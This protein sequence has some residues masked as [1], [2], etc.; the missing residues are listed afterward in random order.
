MW[1]INATQEVNDASQWPMIVAVTIFLS[2]LM[3]GIVSLRIY[4][5]AHVAKAIGGDDYIILVTA[6]FALVYNALC[7]AQ[8][9]YGLGLPIASRPKM[10]IDPYSKLNFAGRPFYQL[11]ISGFKA[12]FCYALLRVTRT[13]QTKFLKIYRATVTAAIVLIVVGHIAGTFILIFQCKP[14]QKSWYPRT[15]GTCL[16]NDTTFYWL[17]GFSILSDLISIFLPLPL[18]LSLNLN[19][20]KRWGLIVPFMLGFFTTICS[21]LRLYQI[22][23]IARDGNSTMLVLWGTIEFNV[24]TMTACL[25]TLVPLFKYFRNRERRTNARSKSSGNW[26]NPATRFFRE[27]VEKYREVDPKTSS[28]IR[29]GQGHSSASGRMSWSKAIEDTQITRTTEVNI[30]HEIRSINDTDS[31]GQHSVMRAWDVRD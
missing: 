29:L 6:I 7:I 11:G 18:L 24:G 2:T 3:V 4:A 25:P 31:G 16:P 28:A 21:V 22:T 30:S 5:R 26:S 27:K 10:N 1:V 15:K 17:G 14:V 23:I 20:R 13:A 19:K 8:T 12:S 9:R